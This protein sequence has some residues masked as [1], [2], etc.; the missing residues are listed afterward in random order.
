MGV[1]PAIVDEGAQSAL[2]LQ[3]ELLDPL[4][5]GIQDFVEHVDRGLV[6]GPHHRHRKLHGDGRLAYP[7]RT[8]K[9][10]SRPVGEAAFQHEV[11]VLYATFVELAG[12]GL[13]MLRGDQPRVDDDAAL[14]DLVVVESLAEV[15]PPDLGHI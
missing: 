8:Q 5:Q 10:R 7:G 14:N 13:V 9:Q 4:D 11:Q 1:E 15:G 12:E 2:I 3:T 6:T